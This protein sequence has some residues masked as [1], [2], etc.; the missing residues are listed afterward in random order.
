M[1]DNF[2]ARLVPLRRQA[3]RNGHSRIEKTAR[4]RFSL[5]VACSHVLYLSRVWATTPA[6]ESCASG[7]RRNPTG[8]IS[9]RPVV[10]G[11]LLNAWATPKIQCDSALGVKLYAPF[12]VH[13]VEIEYAF[14][15]IPHYAKELTAFNPIIGHIVN[16]FSFQ[17]D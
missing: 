14:T 10:G 3:E 2:E 17:G 11:S 9:S 4:G 5:D 12:P 6:N 8:R 15:A 13:F 16:P 7:R 1:G